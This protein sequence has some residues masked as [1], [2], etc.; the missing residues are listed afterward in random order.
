MNELL[1]IKHIIIAM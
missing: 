1:M